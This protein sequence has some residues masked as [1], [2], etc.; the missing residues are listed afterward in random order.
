MRLILGG[1]EI[2]LEA[3]LVLF[4][5]GGVSSKIRRKTLANGKL[6]EQLIIAMLGQKCDIT[7]EPTYDHLYKIDFVVDRFKYIMALR[8]IGVQVTTRLADVAKQNEFVNARGRKSLV[9]RCIY[10]E[11]D[12]SVDVSAYGAELAYN[13]IVGFAFRDDMKT[14]DLVGVR[15]K[16]DVSYEYFDVLA[17]IDAQPAPA[18]GYDE[19]LTGRIVRYNPSKGYGFIKA[20]AGDWFFHISEAEPGIEEMLLSAEYAASG[21]LSRPVPVSFRNAGRKPGTSAS[22]AE[23]VKLTQS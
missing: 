2:I 9:Q 14:Q 12:P 6:V 11:V 7:T 4:E 13:A 8:H 21:Y 17:A 5:N 1:G 19:Y 16:P 10:M 22:T 3:L 15:I 23:K 20:E 18:G